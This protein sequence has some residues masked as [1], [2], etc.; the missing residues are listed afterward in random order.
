VDALTIRRYKARV[1]GTPETVT[2]IDAIINKAYRWSKAEQW[3]D[4]NT[5][6]KIT[7]GGMLLTNRNILLS[8]SEDTHT[9][10]VKIEEIESASWQSIRMDCE[11]ALAES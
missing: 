6:T 3:T 11:Q 5:H 9:G 1:A 8:Y 10:V 4:E 2:R 7:E